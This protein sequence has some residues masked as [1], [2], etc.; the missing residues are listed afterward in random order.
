MRNAI[1]IILLGLALTSCGTTYSAPA[2][3][4]A[5]QQAQAAY[6]DC[7]A[8]RQIGALR[9]YRQAAS[10]AEPKVLSAYKQSGYP[11]MDL[12]ELE[13][14]ARATAADHLDT[15]Y[16]T[17]A[18]VD[19]DMAELEHRIADERERRHEGEMSTGG[20]ASYVPPL[21]LLAGLDALT[22]RAPP[23]G[24]A[25]CFTVGSFSHCE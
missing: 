23:R 11:Y 21:Q 25:N 24:S 4:E 10:C 16:A 8:Q 6:A 20:S 5:E 22:E 13:L 14:L 15:G 9:S 18:Q 1:I 12:V 19:R 3:R 17:T 2:V 7:D